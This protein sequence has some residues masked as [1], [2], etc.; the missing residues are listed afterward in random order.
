VTPSRRDPL[1]ASVPL[2][3]DVAGCSG[4]DDDNTEPTA[5]E[6]AADQEA[7]AESA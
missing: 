7:A 5:R 1:A 3:L 6:P 2:A 4:G